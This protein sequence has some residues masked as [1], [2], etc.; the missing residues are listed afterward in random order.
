MATT[1]THESR[2][3]EAGI[4]AE[5]QK[6]LNFIKKAAKW[7]VIILL[8]IPLYWSGKDYVKE[9]RAEAEKAKAEEI[10]RGPAAPRNPTEILVTADF[11][12]CFT[13]PVGPFT[14][15]PIGKEGNVKFIYPDGYVARVGPKQR[16]MRNFE[17]G[18]RVCVILDDGETTPI[19][20]G[21]QI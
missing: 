14:I 3:K 13:I 20:M 12:S 21:L 19:K 4:V 9:Y 8:V 10:A 1:D 16:I 2:T 18:E 7:P 5:S 11:P 15:Y 17:G 6:P